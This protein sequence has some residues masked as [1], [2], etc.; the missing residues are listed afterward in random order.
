LSRIYY[1]VG[2]LEESKL[3][4]NLA[5]EKG[6]LGYWSYS[7]N[8]DSLIGEITEKYGEEYASLLFLKSDSL[9][10]EKLNRYK[11]IMDSIVQ[12]NSADQ[13]LRSDSINK[14]CRRYGNKYRSS[15]D[16]ERAP[17]HEE[18]MSCYNKYRTQDSLVLQRFV[19]LIENIGHI[20][21]DDI[22]FGVIPLAPL[23]AHTGHFNFKNLDR[24]YKKSVSLGT[25]SPSV[26]AWYK[27]S[28]EIWN[29]EEETLY[30]LWIPEELSIEIEEID[31]KRR[32]LGIPLCPAVLWNTK[33]L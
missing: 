33:M 5:V 3:Q 25:L 16:F 8:E 24:I 13:E 26:Y 2:K 27:S 20:P 31:K 23:V 29:R 15:D 4:M 18:L 6:M 9:L 32:E 30:F 22:V 21:G 19:D 12:I 7:K 10:R 11:H 1:N 17:D 14:I 28:N